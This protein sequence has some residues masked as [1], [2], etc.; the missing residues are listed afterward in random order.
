LVSP[1]ENKFLELDRIPE[2]DLWIR[3]TGLFKEDPD[4]NLILTEEN[5]KEDTELEITFEE[6]IKQVKEV[7]TE[8][9]VLTEIEEMFQRSYDDYKKLEK[10]YEELNLAF[11]YDGMKLNT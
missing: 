7:K 11:A 1:D 6:T 2:L 9:V 5:Y 4:G 10:D 8:K 3:E